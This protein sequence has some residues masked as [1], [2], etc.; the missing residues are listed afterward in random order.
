MKKLE[1]QH[2]SYNKN[3]YIVYKIKKNKKQLTKTNKKI[4]TWH[5]LLFRD[6]NE[7]VDSCCNSRNNIS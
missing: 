3:E 6:V 7:T 2:S 5:F 1:I 4:K